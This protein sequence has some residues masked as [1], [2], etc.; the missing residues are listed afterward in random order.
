MQDETTSAPTRGGWWLDTAAVT[1]D[2]SALVGLVGWLNAP[3]TVAPAILVVLLVAALVVS[4]VRA[5]AQ[6]VDL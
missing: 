1:L 4:F 2:L 3:Q 5:L 6:V